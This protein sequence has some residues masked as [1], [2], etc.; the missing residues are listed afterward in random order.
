MPRTLRGSTDSDMTGART[1]SLRVI[2]FLLSIPSGGVLLTHTYGLLPMDVGGWLVALPCC[3]ALAAWVRWGNAEVAE[4]IAIGALA[5]FVGTLLYDIA[6]VPVLMAGRRV[7]APIE[8]YGL[9]LLDAPASSRFT[10]L[11]GWLYHFSNG[12]TF[13]IMYALLM[14]G[15]H[16][17]WAVAWA[18]VLETIFV[19][20]PLAYSVALFTDSWAVVVAYYGHV[21]YGIGLGWLVQ[22]WD[23][24]RG[25]LRQ[26]EPA[27]R[28]LLAA[29]PVVICGAYILN[30]PVEQDRRVRAGT[31]RVEGARLNPDWVRLKAGGSVTIENPGPE[32]ATV[33]IPGLS[34]TFDIAAGQAVSYIFAQPSGLFDIF[35]VAVAVS[36]RSRSSFVV[37]EP[38]R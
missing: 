35:Q 34:Q 19:L 9:W 15:R 27:H 11:T 38:A 28:L 20:S 3:L 18:F 25:Q 22:R 29:V 13:G 17:I 12:I 30:G 26:L 7:F 1:R 24:S 23:W 32:R 6:R 21:A 31:L 2:A 16:W 33:R 36:G 5:G 14:R 37:V 10:H 4:A 8:L